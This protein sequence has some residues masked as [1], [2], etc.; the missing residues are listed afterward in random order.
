VNLVARKYGYRSDIKEVRY[1]KE[2]E[3]VFGDSMVNGEHNYVLRKYG[4]DYYEMEE[5]RRVDEDYRRAFEEALKTET[6]NQENAELFGLT[7]EGIL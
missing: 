2:R 7:R 4:V 1:N 3:L 6:W 5:S